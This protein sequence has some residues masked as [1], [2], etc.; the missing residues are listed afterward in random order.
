M[1]D[2]QA[3]GKLTLTGNHLKRAQA[4]FESV[5]VDDEETVATIREVHSKYGYLLDPHSAVGYTAARTISSSSPVISLACA[6][7]AKF[8]AAIE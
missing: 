6:H 5:R 8:A 1:T 2:F 7:P 3:S 4:Q